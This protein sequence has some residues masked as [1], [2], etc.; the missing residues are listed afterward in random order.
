MGLRFDPRP[1]DKTT[2]CVYIYI[3]IMYVCIY[4]YIERDIHMYIYIYIYRE[5]E[6]S[7][8]I[9][10]A[11]SENKMRDLGSREKGGG[12]PLH[13]SSRT[14][15]SSRPFSEDCETLRRAASRCPRARAV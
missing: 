2:M 5:R 11:K 1:E 8:V 12:K 9:N 10:D 13:G 7:Y 4:I 3:Y 6:R 15:A 14:F